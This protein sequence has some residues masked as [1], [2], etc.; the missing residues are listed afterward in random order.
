MKSVVKIVG[1]EFVLAIL[2]FP[3]IGNLVPL[4]V[5]Y[6]IMALAAMLLV[7]KLPLWAFGV[8]ANLAGGGL[9]AVEDSSKYPNPWDPK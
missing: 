3:I 4:V 1:A 9:K 5:W 7:I 6:W 8:M 2:V